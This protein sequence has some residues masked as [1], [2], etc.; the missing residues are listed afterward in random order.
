MMRSSCS[1]LMILAF[2]VSSTLIAAELSPQDF[3]YGMAVVTPS[4]AAAYR[5]AVPPEVYLKAVRPNLED[6]QIFNDRGESVPYAIEQPPAPSSAPAPQSVLP[7]FVL[8]DD[9]PDALRAMRVTVASQGS[10]VSVETPGSNSA[11]SGA[12]SYILDGTRLDTPVAAIH[13]HWPADAPDFAGRIR[14]EAGDTLGSLRNVVAAAPI[15]NLHSDAAQLIEDRIELP[16]TRAKFWRLSWVGKPPAFQLVSATAEAATDRDTAERSRLVVAGE[17]VRDK[18]GEVQFDLGARPPVD[19]LNLELPELNTVINAQF[20]SRAD[21][22]SPWHLEAQGGFY[23]LQGTDGEL[24]NSALSVEITPERFWLVRIPQTKTALGNG[25][26]RLE[27]QWRASQ[28]VFLARGKPPFTLAYGSG[29][30]IGTA[31]SLVALPT[32][33]SPIAA[34]LTAPKMLGGDSRL[35]TRSRDLPWK[36]GILW[37]ILAAAVVLLSAIALR[38]TRDLKE[39][40]TK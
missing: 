36:T 15:A 39:S 23:R 8:R 19:R 7:L 31:I 28:L 17:P 14:V 29:Y 2:A 27:V 9:T 37:A 11:P 25:S 40:D 38:L 3:A 32:S 30:A 24:R 34:T 12:I 13:V 33:A 10:A 22:A 16:A 21:P 4:D 35:K 18:P 5:L 6:I 1:L 20:L 26:L